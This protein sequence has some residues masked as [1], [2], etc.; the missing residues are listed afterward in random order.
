MT[1][2][3]Q[4]FAGLSGLIAAS[5]LPLPLQI[6]AATT[7]MPIRKTG[8]YK[9]MESSAQWRRD[10]VARIEKLRKGD[11]HV[12][13]QDAEG[14]PLPGIEL[15]ASQYRHEFGFGA[16]I[17]PSFLFN[18]GTPETQQFYRETTSAYFH[19]ITIANGLKW[20]HHERLKHEVDTCMKWCG[21]QQ[22]PVR[23]HCLVWPGF[24]RIPESLSHL[25][26]DP[27]LLRETIEKHISEFVSK[28]DEPL[29]EWDVLNEPFTEHEFMDLLGPGVVND[30]FRIAKETNP[31][32]KRYI[33]DYGVLTRPSKKHQDF[34]FDFIHEQLGSGTAIDGIGF[35]SHIP[36]RFD[37]TPPVD[38]LHTMDR[39][40]VLGLPLQV[41][42]FDFETTDRDLQARYTA[43][44]ITAVFSHP[45]MTGLITWS[46][47]EYADG[48]SS[49]P[50]AALFDLRLNERPNGQVWNALINRDWRTDE[51]LVTDEAGRVSFRGFK[52]AYNLV[53]TAG[54]K[55]LERQVTFK[56]DGAQNTLTLSENI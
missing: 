43:D 10:A 42:E 30:W 19:R 25:R 45:A 2:R 17:K 16:A 36:A 3:R 4:F 44:F 13:V 27:Q 11:F 51:M 6:R 47:Y 38:L 1:P 55:R 39:F 32:L 21:E 26:N 23:G 52:G 33:N 8:R 22:L 37:P 49:K 20:K 5:L 46:P 40:A 15:R 56:G 35:Q 24:R 18:R 31:R 9:G 54:G 7:E 48:H 12:L 41:T 53:T 29:I 34:Y 28:Y 14:R 50:D